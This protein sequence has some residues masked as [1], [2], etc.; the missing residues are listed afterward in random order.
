MKLDHCNSC[1]REL[2][3]AFERYE[4]DQ[5][6]ARGDLHF[7]HKVCEDAYKERISNANN[8]PNNKRHN[9]QKTT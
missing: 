6:I 8:E 9:I 5:Y 2:E 1:E 4:I 3:L 7:C